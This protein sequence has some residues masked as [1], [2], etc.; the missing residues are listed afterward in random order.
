MLN[1][2]ENEYDNTQ[3]D[4]ED[5]K[6]DDEY[7]KESYDDTDKYEEEAE[8]IESEH[9]DDLSS[10]GWIWLPEHREEYQTLGDMADSPSSRWNRTYQGT[11]KEAYCEDTETGTSIDA[12]IEDRMNDRYSLLSER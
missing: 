6:G 8:D 9:V 5:Y 10:W 7:H 12:D 4:I 11:G 1:C 3:Q 2:T